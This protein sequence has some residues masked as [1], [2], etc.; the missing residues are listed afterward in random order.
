M[1]TRSKGCCR[2]GDPTLTA[3]DSSPFE[4]E[5]LPAA[6]GLA[7]NL[8]IDRVKEKAGHASE[9]NTL[10]KE[11]L[12]RA[13]TTPP[14]ARASP[15]KT[16]IPL[17]SSTR[18]INTQANVLFFVFKTLTISFL[19]SVLFFFL[20]ANDQKGLGSFCVF[21]AAPHN[22]SKGIEIPT[23]RARSTPWGQAWPTAQRR[24]WTRRES[25]GADRRP[26]APAAWAGQL[27]VDPGACK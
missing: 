23:P 15:P 18:I 12:T 22:S 5:L 11:H 24:R 13:Q 27:G 9:F 3:T 6:K 8:L 19:L 26:S 21:T 4:T 20:I 17:F 1:L 14:P 2:S 10:T 16:L 7:H 25:P